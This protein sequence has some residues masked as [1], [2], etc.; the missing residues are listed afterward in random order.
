[1]DLRQLRYFVAIAERGSFSAAASAL[2]VAQSALSRHMQALEHEMGGLLF[3]RGRHGIAISESGKILLDRARYMLGE[4]DNIRA[5]VSLENREPGGMVRLGAP[6]T[7]ADILFAPLALHFARRFPR[8]RV[9]FSEGLTEELCD[10]VLRGVLDLAIV[11]APQR[12]EH[13]EFIDLFH[14]GVYMLGRPGDPHLKTAA[15]SPADIVRLP[16]ILPLSDTT[17][18]FLPDRPI[19]SFEVDNMEP[20][21][22][23]VMA[24]IG[25]GFLPYSG[26]HRELAAG[27][28]GAVELP[29]VQARRVLALPRG[30]PASRATREMIAAIK[31][32][33]ATLIA[34]GRIRCVE[35]GTRR[36]R[37]A[38]AH[39]KRSRKN[40]IQ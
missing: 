3:E 21:K 31:T 7:L 34:E 19:C 24:G 29:W 14:E 30:R 4:L 40:S 36:R 8:V 17:R 1:M 5:E 23:M 15:L 16:L 12:V 6:S 32:V 39:R 33:S 27:T 25:Y 35:P 9:Q 22:Q 2:N 38:N 18:G 20:L 28:L 10:R 11:T 13:L 37:S 26:F